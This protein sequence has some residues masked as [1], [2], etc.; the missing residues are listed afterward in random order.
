MNECYDI[1]EKR[2]PY[3][4][5]REGWV[6]KPA[7]TL[8]YGQQIEGKIGRFWRISKHSWGWCT[9]PRTRYDRPISGKAT[10]KTAALQTCI[11]AHVRGYK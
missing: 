10:T 9:V 8:R 11:V 6:F 1:M 5:K 7:V 3:H 4:L 2:R